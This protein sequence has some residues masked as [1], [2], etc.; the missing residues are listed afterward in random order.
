MAGLFLN[1]NIDLLRTG[2]FSDLVI[3]CGSLEFQVHKAVVCAASPKLSA[4]CGG[5]F[6]V[7]PST[8]R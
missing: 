1:D 3:E 2:T 7:S 4:A 5:Q 6:K 8:Y